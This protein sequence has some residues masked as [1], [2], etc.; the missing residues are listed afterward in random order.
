MFGTQSFVFASASTNSGVFFL[1]NVILLP[2][3]ERDME[4]VGPKGDKHPCLL[5]ECVLGIGYR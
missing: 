4:V 1:Y 2:I 3:I 5:K